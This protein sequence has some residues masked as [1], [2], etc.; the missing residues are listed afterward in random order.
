MKKIFFIVKKS[1]LQHK[2]STVITILSVALAAALVMSVFSIRDQAES[3]FTGGPNGF[4]AV[5]GARGSQLQ[6]VLNTIFHLETSP[7]NIPWSDYKSLKD[8]P[9]VSLAVPYAV[10]DNYKGYRIVG[11]TAEIFN[12]FEYSKG[13]AF[14]FKTG[15]PFNP[16][17]R[18]AVVG[19]YVAQKTGLKKGSVFNAYHG[20]DYN[21]KSRH[22]DKYEVTGVLKPTN[23]PSD[24]VIWIPIDQ[25]Y[26]T[27]GH[28]LRGAGE[29]Y[30]AHEHHNHDHHDD[31]GANDIPDEHKEISAVM[32]KLK[33]P[34]SGFKLANE[35]NRQG[36]D[37]TLA[38]PI[39]AVLAELFEKIGWVTKILT[40]VAYL[41]IVVAAGSILASIYNTMNERRREFAILRALG[42]KK[43]TVFSSV[44]IEAVTISFIGTAIGFI[45]YFILMSF[46]SFI[47]RQ[48]TGVVI[49]IF[50]LHPVLLIAPAVMIA[51]GAL[52]GI[53]P[54]YKAYRTEVAGG[55]SPNS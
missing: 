51:L 17:R 24:R 23:S 19:S 5:L 45:F 28:V 27:E 25:F 2:L 26:L 54:A 33:T 21:E 4:D 52:A 40:L 42:A 12:E 14:E 49:D 53:I 15:G 50:G 10:G 7:G 20:I 35:Y 9:S 39:G 46:A 11:T 1:L 47:I 18:E 29:D 30:H 37:T 3:A 36:K 31:H 38:W 44:V 6:L 16:K 48:Q 43:G 22:D 32:L 13:K 8:N 34:A 41:V 55:L